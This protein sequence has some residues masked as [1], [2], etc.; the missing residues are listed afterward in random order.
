VGSVSPPI[1]FCF[2]QPLGEPVIEIEVHLGERSYPVRVGPWR[3]WDVRSVTRDWP[4][5][6]WALICDRRVWDVW[7]KDL[8]ACLGSAQIDVHVLEIE[9][10]E[11]AKT[12]SNLFRIYDHLLAHKVRR[13]GT[14]AVF[15]GGVLGDLAGF[16]AA[17]WQRG[18]RFVQIPTTLLAQVDSSVGGKTGLNYG[19]HKNMIGTFHQPGAVLISPEWLASLTPRE[20]SAGLAEVI[21]CGVIRDLELL[22]ILEEEDPQ[23]LGRSP[24]LE[25]VVARALMVKAHMVEEDERDYGLRHLLNFGHTVGHALEAATGFT[26]FLHGEAVSLGMLASLR[27]SCVVAGLSDDEVARV[28]AVLE[29]HGLPVSANGIDL[30]RTLDGLNFDKK[31]ESTG[32]AW[33][34]TPRLGTASVFSQVP[35]SQIR[36][37]VAHILRP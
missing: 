8:L 13:D 10:G 32:S 9:G 12:H 26:R 4:Q 7:S 30:D 17:T 6:P 24:R 27:L 22:R 3:D 37:A 1:S 19:E 33:V 18:I 29:R 20:F 21:K 15:G 28:E 23:R 2:V 35:I 36:E 25:E 31:V 16:A 34:L 11:P 5:S 14:L